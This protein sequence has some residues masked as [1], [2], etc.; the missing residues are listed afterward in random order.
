M[1]TLYRIPF[2]PARKP[3]PIRLL[4]KHRNV[5][6]GAINVTERSCAAPISKIGASHIGQVLCHTL[7]HFERLGIRA[8]AEALK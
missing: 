7:V 1:F 3:K 2:A 6:F 8:V 4:F 5:D